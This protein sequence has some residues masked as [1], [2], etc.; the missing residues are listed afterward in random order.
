MTSC[1]YCGVDILFGGVRVE[2]L[3]Y[4]RSACQQKAEEAERNISQARQAYEKCLAQLRQTP[5]DPHLR[6]Q[7]L[8]AGRLHAAWKRHREG[9]KVTVY[10]E[11]AIANEIEAASAA[12]AANPK[13]TNE[14]SMSI[15]ERLERLKA[16]KGN[17]L[18]SSE[19][20]EA[21]RAAILAEL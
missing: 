16:L 20:Y 18:I 11:T 2:N 3:R 17:N 7:A 1:A 15:E 19:E 5:A 9:G 21:K 14:G 4:C 6:Q 12:V 10:D 13:R 8:E